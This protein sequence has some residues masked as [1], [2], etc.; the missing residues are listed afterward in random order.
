MQV[1]LNSGTWRGSSRRICGTQHRVPFCGILDSALPLQSLGFRPHCCGQRIRSQR[2]TESKSRG[3]S[4][5][6]IVYPCRQG[7]LRSA[8]KGREGKDGPSSFMEANTLL[9]WM[10]WTSSHSLLPR[11][12]YSSEGLS[13]EP[14]T[15]HKE[16]NVGTQPGCNSLE[17]HVHAAPWLY[18]LIGN[19]FTFRKKL[20]MGAVVGNC[21]DMSEE[22]RLFA[23]S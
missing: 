18:L 10:Q 9:S 20:K 17:K 23:D 19:R 16:K 3:R 8:H 1:M 13:L 14:S 21:P 12:C 4:K 11:K 15:L 2:E 7:R 5:L 6:V 22:N